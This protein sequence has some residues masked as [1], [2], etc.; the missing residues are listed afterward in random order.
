VEQNPSEQEDWLGNLNP[1]SKVV[2]PDAYTVPLLAGSTLGD[3]F[4]FDRLG[5]I[6]TI[7]FQYLCSCLIVL[8]IGT[9]NATKPAISESNLL[10]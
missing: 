4:Q 6:S 8:C 5:K 1:H 10:V 9:G 7:L 3:R 2:I